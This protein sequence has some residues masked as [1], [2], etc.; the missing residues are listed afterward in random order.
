M[1]REQMVEVL[2]SKDELE[3]VQAAAKV[4][5]LDLASFVRHAALAFAGRN[6]QRSYTKYELGSIHREAVSRGHRWEEAELLERHL[7]LYWSEDWVRA[8]LAEGKSVK[9][10]AILC[11]SPQTSVGQY[12][13]QQYDIRAFRKLTEADIEQIRREYVAGKSRRQIAAD[14]EISASTVGKHIRNL[15][16]GHK[17]TLQEQPQSD[18]LELR[19]VNLN[20]SWARRMFEERIKLIESWPTTTNIIAARVF[21]GDK[22]AA[23]SW[24]TRMVDR[25]WLVRLSQGKFDLPSKDLAGIEDKMKV[26]ART[27]E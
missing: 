25:G 8:R 13:Q 9:Q 2:F 7:P 27:G 22:P 5:S 11:S 19:V 26:T 21:S 6:Q 23:I 24:T 12:L 14:M 16:P 4:V 18:Q 15:I 20:K 17:W 1:G 3:Q 10:L